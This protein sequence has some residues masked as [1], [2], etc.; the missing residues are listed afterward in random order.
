MTTHALVAGLALAALEERPGDCHVEG[1]GGT[2][3]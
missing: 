3:L 1:G 2:P